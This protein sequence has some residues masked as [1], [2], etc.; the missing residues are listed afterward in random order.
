MS[1]MRVSQRTLANILSSFVVDTG[2]ATKED[3]RLLVDQAKVT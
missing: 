3:P 1:A 2:L